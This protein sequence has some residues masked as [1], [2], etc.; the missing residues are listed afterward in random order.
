MA[1]PQKVLEQLYREPPR[2]PGWAWQFLMFG[3]TVF[4]I[5]L[6]VYVG[7]VFGYK[8][9]LSSQLRKTQDKIQAFSQQIPAEEQFKIVDFY[10]QI[11]NLKSLI[12]KHILTSPFFEWLEK[13][14]QG[15][16]YFEQL[17]LNAANGRAILSGAA[18]SVE[19][20]TQQLA[21]FESRPE[22]ERV[23]IGPTNF[24]GGAWRFG[25]VLYFNQ[26]Y[27][28]RGGAQL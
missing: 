1:L 19:D 28:L 13:N 5:S 11:V 14:T 4:F 21:I 7:L 16:I 2:T 12:E 10:S 18:K 3:T 6:L 26:G 22:V 20:I 9:F 25:I 24:S 15:N 8:P 27:F 17:D 23:S